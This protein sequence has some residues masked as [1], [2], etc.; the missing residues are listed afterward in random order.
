MVSWV[1]WRWAVRLVDVVLPPCCLWCHCGL[2]HRVERKFCSACWAE[3]AQETP[4]KCL[5]CDAALVQNPSS[6]RCA[7]CQSWPR[8]LG[9]VVSL[10]PY[11]GALRRA[12]LRGK[13][14]HGEALV[15]GLGE[16][17]GQEVQRRGLPPAELVVPVPLHWKRRLLRQTNPASTLALHVA[18]VLRVPCRRLI[19]RRRATQSQ[20]GLSA[21]ARWHNVHRAFAP[22]SK[23]DLG[24][25][26]VLLV[27]DILTT[28]ATASQAAG[29][30][31]HLGA[32]QVLVA[33]LA[34][35]TSPAAR[36]ASA[37]ASPAPLPHPQSSQEVLNGVHK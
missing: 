16:A 27:D 8:W 9:P 4:S 35:A 36:K 23:M 17:L 3:L 25:K 7:S 20:G 10:G 5:W 28:G 11:Q 33:V 34:R 26:T 1:G 19:R 21:W 2:P 18:Q 30:L 37:P 6:A 31:R 32:A 12:V 13:T 15:A 22:W 24:G 14:V 29:V